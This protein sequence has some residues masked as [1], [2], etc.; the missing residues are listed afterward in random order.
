M[1]QNVVTRQK[2]NISENDYFG[3]II[4]QAIIALSTKYDHTLL[5]NFQRKRF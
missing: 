3:Y 4:K 5:I 1:M 2:S